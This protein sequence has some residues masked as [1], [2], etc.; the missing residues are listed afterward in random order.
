[1]VISDAWAIA[2]PE[3]FGRD[4]EHGGVQNLLRS[5]RLQRPFAPTSQMRFDE[6]ISVPCS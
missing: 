4:Y 3:C 1:M 5:Q 2:P 6:S